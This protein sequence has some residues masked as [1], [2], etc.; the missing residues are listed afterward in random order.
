MPTEEWGKMNKIACK[1]FDSEEQSFV[2]QK[3][4]IFNHVFIFLLQQDKN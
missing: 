2:L 1:Y 4:G 3:F